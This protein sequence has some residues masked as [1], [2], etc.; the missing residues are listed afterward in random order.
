MT[1]AVALKTWE[2]LTDPDFLKD[3]RKKGEFL[4]SLLKEN[5][6]KAGLKGEIRGKGLLC[7][8]VT[9]AVT[10]EKIRLSSKDARRRD[11]FCSGRVPM[12]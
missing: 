8:L 10:P 5:L 2:I 12:S 7:G 1:T 4:K 6:Q 11:C 9:E 3:V